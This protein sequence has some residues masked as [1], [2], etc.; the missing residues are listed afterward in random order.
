[1]ALSLELDGGRYASLYG[2]VRQLKLRALKLRLPAEADAVQ[3]LTVHGAK[4]LEARVVILLDCDA[5][6]ARAESS[7]LA[8]DW[9]V[10]SSAPKTVAF[11][12]SESKAPPALQ[13]LLDFEREQREREE[14]NALYVALTRARSMLV[15]SR[16]PARRR[17]AQPSW[18]ERLV[19]FAPAF[20]IDSTHSQAARSLPAPVLLELPQLPQQPVPAPAQA[21]PLGPSTVDAD[22]LAPRTQ[23][24]DDSAALGEAMHR[25]LEWFS[26]PLG[27]SHPLL[28]LCASAAQMYGLDKRRSERLQAAVQ[29]ILSSADCA[30]LF[31]P[32]AL[33]WAGNEVPVAWE[34]QDM[35]IDRLVQLREPD[36]VPSWWVLDYKLNAEPQ[37]DADYREQL[38]RY[39]RA[40]SALQ[41]GERVRTFFITSQGRLIESAAPG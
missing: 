39:R 28:Q 25:V 16:T 40:V 12:S 5:G 20:P 11:I 22:S 24:L 29:A 27:R 31:D 23:S 13:P 6:P 36:G 35:R 26:G 34:G 10:Q 18:W 1:M 4:G 38:E 33:L 7:T 3:L 37:R 32:Q 19:E 17:A 21:V 30:P 8:L 41:P 14:L 15:I 9:P 2:F